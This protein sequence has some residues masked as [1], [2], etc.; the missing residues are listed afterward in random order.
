MINIPFFILFFLSVLGLIIN[1]V[2]HG[3][4]RGDY[5]AY[6]SFI[7]DTIEL[8]LIYWAIKWGNIL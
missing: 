2:N 5:D 3:K 6:I 1:I 7:S 8:I 4:S